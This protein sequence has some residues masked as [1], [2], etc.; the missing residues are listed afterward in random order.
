MNPPP[1]PLDSNSPAE[2]SAKSAPV[3]VPIPK[4]VARPKVFAARPVATRRKPRVVVVG[5]AIQPLYITF[6]ILSLY[7]VGSALWRSLTAASEYGSRGSAI[8][9]MVMDGLGVVCLFLLYLRL[10]R[11]PSYRT[12]FTEL[13]FYGGLIAGIVLFAIRCSGKVGWWTGHLRLEWQ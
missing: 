11:I 3:P 9:D 13:Y 4:V 1:A 5:N 12:F 10:K 2:A 8:T 6:L 7:L